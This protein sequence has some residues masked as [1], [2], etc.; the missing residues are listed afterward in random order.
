MKII[1]EYNFTLYTILAELCIRSDYVNVLKNLIWSNKKF[2]ES[3]ILAVNI[4]AYSEIWSA[5]ET[6]HTMHSLH[7]S[8]SIV[9]LNFGYCSPMSKS[10]FTGLDSYIPYDLITINA[11]EYPYGCHNNSNGSEPF[12]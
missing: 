1:S 12:E 11:H 4:T 9:D 8:W 6:L 7:A 3:N 10:F 5:K 2:L